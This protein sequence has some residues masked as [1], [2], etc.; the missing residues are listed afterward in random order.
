MNLFLAWE[1]FEVWQEKHQ[2]NVQPMRMFFLNLLQ[3]GI[4][5][6]KEFLDELSREVQG[7]SCTE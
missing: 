1:F 6:L 5:G 7:K 3:R 4:R 2:K